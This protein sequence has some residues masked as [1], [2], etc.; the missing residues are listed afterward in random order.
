MEVATN[1]LRNLEEQLHDAEMGLKNAKNDDE[2]LDYEFKVIKLRDDIDEVNDKLDYLIVLSNEKEKEVRLEEEKVI[3]YK[4][5]YINSDEKSVNVLSSY[6][7]IPN[8]KSDVLKY[9]KN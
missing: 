9:A 2:K 5:L 7:N 6:F 1:E 3:A 8:N 4:K